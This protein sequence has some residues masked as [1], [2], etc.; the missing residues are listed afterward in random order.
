MGLPSGCSAFYESGLI[1]VQIEASP[2]TV[3]STVDMCLQIMKRTYGEGSALAE[4][5]PL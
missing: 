3:G 2:E 1:G 4:G 5:I